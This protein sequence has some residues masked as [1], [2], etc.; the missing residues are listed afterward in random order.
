MLGAAAMLNPTF[1]IHDIAIDT[2]DLGIDLTGEAK[3][4]PLAPNRL[5]CGR[6]PGRARF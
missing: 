4:S 6:R 3:G 1:R 2:E 5:H